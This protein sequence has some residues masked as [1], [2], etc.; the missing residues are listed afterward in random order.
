M[1]STALILNTSPSTLD[2]EYCPCKYCP[3]NSKYYELLSESGYWKAMHFKAKQQIEKLL[4]ENEVLNAKLKLRERQL[5]GRK[6]EKPR[7]KNQKSSIENNQAG[8][9]NRRGQQPGR[10]GHGRSRQ[11]NL[12]QIEEAYELSDEDRICPGCDLPYE[13]FPGSDDSEVIEIEVKPYRRLIRRKRYKRTCQCNSQPGI[14]TAPGPGKLIPKGRFGVSFWVQVL[15]DKYRWQRAT[16][17]LMQQLETYGLHVS[18]G[19]VTGGLKQ[20]T[21]LFEPIEQGII[22]MN[23]KDNHWHADETRWMV[24]VEFEGKN[25]YRWYL[26]LFQGATTVVFKLRPS[27]GAKVAEEHF[28]E[29]ASGIIS[30]DRYSAYKVLLKTGRF[31]I[32]FCWSHVRRDFLNLANEWVKL[33]VWAMCWVEKIG[34]LYYLNEQRLQWELGSEEF[35]QADGKLRESIEQMKK[36]RDQQLNG[37][38]IHYACKKV[39]KSLMEHWSGLTLFVDYPWIPMDNNTAE[40]TMRDPVLGRKNY[41]GC[42]S[43]WSA[44][45]MA[46][47]FTVIY[48]VEL[49]GINSRLWLEE[50]LQEC[51]KGNGKVPTNPQRFLPWN[52]PREELIRLGADPEN[53]PGIKPY[54]LPRRLRCNTVEE[55]SPPGRLTQS[56]ESS[57]RAPKKRGPPCPER[58]VRNSDGLNRMG[59]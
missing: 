24:F 11:D 51:A 39:L 14:I 9:K 6:S 15:L 36:E 54:I 47:M 49:W 5:F 2:S 48:T 37:P 50:Y 57:Q 34:N 30:A 32:A 23:Q 10:K 21:P 8:R 27:R 12:P 35:I 29:T 42:G 40:R 45:L 7:N 1:K 3:S 38:N 25:G 53:L 59:A 41:Y 56:K 55:S 19:T 33:E 16:H 18:P 22:Q 52:M 44:N 20:L 28:G 31:L 26:W 58:F 43:L 46:M 4:K 13:E 17:R